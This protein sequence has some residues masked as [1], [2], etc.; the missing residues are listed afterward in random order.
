MINGTDGTMFPPFIKKEDTLYMYAPE[1]CRSVSLVY[2]SD[3][4]YE[5]IPGYKFVLTKDIFD[6]QD[7]YPLNECFCPDVKEPLVQDCPVNGLGRLLSCKADVP[8]AISKP[9]FLDAGGDVEM[10]ARVWG[11][12]PVRERHEAYVEVEPVS[13]ILT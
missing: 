3:V 13:L 6:T 8:I 12:S 5:G 11:L 1:I 7:K 2:D 10:N 9:H 4:E